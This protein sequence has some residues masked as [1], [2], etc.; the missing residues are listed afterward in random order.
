MV[1]KLIFFSVIVILSFLGCKERNT[2][3]NVKFIMVQK[4]IVIPI[5]DSLKFEHEHQKEFKIENRSSIREF[6][7]VI[8]NGRKTNFVKF[9][10]TYNFQIV[11]T[12]STIDEYIGCAKFIKND[13]ATYIIDENI[14]DLIM[15][16]C[17]KQ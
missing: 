9:I 5:D 14:E 15:K 4:Q 7:I 8:E 11:Y 16:C 6:M 3:E 2:Y 13:E 1:N 17:H 12:D 10:K